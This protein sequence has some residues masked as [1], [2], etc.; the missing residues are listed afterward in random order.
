MNALSGQA[1]VER[2]VAA[3]NAFDIDGMVAGLAPDVRFENWSGGELTVASD[4][5]AAFRELA[6]RAR[7]M[8]SARAQRIT[9]LAPRGDNLVATI[10]WRGTLAIDL[11]DGPAA[12]AEIALQGESE[13]GFADGR[14]ARIVD[15]G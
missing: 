11:P 10:D 14:I 13:F 9:A 8:F 1:L 15:R 2:Y 5:V 6:E 4:G 7:G 12:G 3:Y